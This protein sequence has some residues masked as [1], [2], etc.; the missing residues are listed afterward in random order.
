MIE[1]ESPDLYRQQ[2][3]DKVLNKSN[4]RSD[5]ATPL[6]SPFT[7]ND[8]SRASKSSKMPTTEPKTRRISKK[9]SK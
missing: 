5:T 9:S 3:N 4:G 6:F 8:S 2:T 1:I 7:L